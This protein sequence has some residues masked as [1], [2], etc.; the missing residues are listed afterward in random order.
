MRPI[1]PCVGLM[2][3]ATCRA[4]PTPVAAPV[5]P[6]CWRSDRTALSMEPTVTALDAGMKAY[7]FADLHR[8]RDGDAIVLQGTT[9]HSEEP[10]AV[11]EYRVRLVVSPVQDS[12]RYQVQAW[13]VTPPGVAAVTTDSSAAKNVSLGICGIAVPQSR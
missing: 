4:A 2:L 8:T 3:A 11:A 5:A 12:T 7:G 13:F 9:R 10:A 6:Y 1:V